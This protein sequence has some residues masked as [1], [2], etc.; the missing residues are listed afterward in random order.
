MPCTDKHQ[1]NTKYQIEIRGNLD[2]GWSGCF[3]K[4]ELSYQEQEHRTI[5]IGLIADQA[6]LRGILNKLWDLNKCI[7]SV[8]QL[9]DRI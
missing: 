1:P 5:L 6:E 8:L 9:Q 3:N 2:D 7:I 4:L